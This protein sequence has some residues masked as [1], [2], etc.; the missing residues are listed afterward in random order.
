MFR[1]RRDAGQK[2]GAALLG[3]GGAGPLMLGIARGG[4]EVAYYAASI[5]GCEMSVLVS[6]KLPFP[7]NPE[8]GFGAMAEDGSTYLNE[9]AAGV[10]LPETVERIK[11]EQ[12]AEVRRRVDVLRRGRPLPEI[13]GRVVIVVDDGIAMGSTMRAG[14]MLCRNR[15]AKE[16]VVASPVAGPS[17]AAA[18]AEI[19]DGVVILEKPR[20]FRAVAEVYENW[21]DVPD[22]EVIG[23]ME[24]WEA[25]RGDKD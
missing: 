14:V 22:A 12:R 7:D 13:G 24:S 16:V 8:S 10:L 11:A 25:E 21:Y 9:Y 3:Y 4:V 5:L 17:V 19:A 1:D 15:R 23:I 2:L 18:F 20:F 6:R